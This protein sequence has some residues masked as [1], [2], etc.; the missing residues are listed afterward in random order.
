MNCPKCGVVNSQDSKFCGSCGFDLSTVQPQNNSIQNSVESQISQNPSLNSNNMIQPNVQPP[1][2]NIQSPVEPQ[3]SQNSSL[4]SNNVIQPSVQPQVNNVQSSVESQISQ[5]QSLDSNN[6]VQAN[7]SIQ[8]LGVT[9]QNFQSNVSQPIA[10][11]NV[12]SLNSS[13]QVTNRKKIVFNKKIVIALI[14]VVVIV[15]AAIVL[16]NIFGKNNEENKKLNAIFGIDNLIKIEENDKYG[17]IDTDGKVVIKPTYDDASDFVGDYA[18]VTSENLV[19]GYKKKSYKVIDRKGVVKLESEYT[20]SY[21]LDSNVWIKEGVLYDSSLKPISSPDVTVSYEG[22]NYFRWSDK[23]DSAGGLMNA[24]GKIIYKYLFESGENYISFE[25]SDNDEGLKDRYCRVNVENEKYA[26][27]NCDSGKIVYD[28]TELYISDQG[29]NV[30]RISN[31]DT[32]SFV[33]LVY[34]Q[35]DKVAYKTDSSSVS[36]SYSPNSK[37]VSVYDYSSNSDSKY[38][39]I[40]IKS[41]KISN[42]KPESDI[43]D[44]EITDEWELLT[45]QTK[46]SCADGYGLMKNDKVILSCE[47]DDL[48]YFGTMLYKY[49]SSKGKNYVLG[50]KKSKSYLIDIKKGKTVAEFNSTYVTDSDDSTFIYYTDSSTKTKTVYNLVTNKKLE[51]IDS[52]SSVSVYSNYITVK[53]NKNKKLK[54]YNS[55]LKLIYTQEL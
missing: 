54:Y 11:Q 49:L 31:H 32:F 26:I 46:F 38:S 15:V 45:K 9:G 27:I 44:V 14:A 40:D 33:S 30:F 4:N 48:D 35:N 36:L 17:Y 39:Y 22:N 43:S 12:G 29:D 1:V 47:W 13:V 20:I 25:I 18:L 8:S 34:I 21:I 42:V 52:S 19:D 41:G 16:L 37:Y 53:D 10:N 23:N 6:I 24:K 2:N 51:S 50:E 7:P 3:I 28:F 5:N 55:D